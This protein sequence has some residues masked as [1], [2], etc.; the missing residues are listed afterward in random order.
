MKLT[1]VVLV[2]VFLFSAGFS[3]RGN[4]YYFS[5]VTGDDTR[6]STQ[7]QQPATPWK[8]ISKLNAYF[9]SL[10]PG[11]TVFLQCGSVFTGPLHIRQ[12]GS[13]GHPIVITSYGT[14]AAPVIS[15]FSTLTGWVSAGGNIWQSSCAACGVRVNILDVADS[16][17]PM[18]RY[19]NSGGSN[20]GYA[21]VQQHTD[22]T[23]IT[24]ASLGLGQNWTGADLVL[25]KNRYIIERDSILLHSGNTIRYK[26]ASAVAATDKFG[27]FIQNSVKTLDK[28]GEWYYD[29]KTR[30]MNMYWSL[31]PAGIVIKA[32]Q[33][34]TLVDII[35]RQYIQ[36]KG[37]SFEGSNRVGFYL[38]QSGNINFTNCSLR[39]SGIDGIKGIQSNDLTFQGVT[40]EYTNNNAIDL[41]GSRSMIQ[42]CNILRTAIF[43]G[44]G[45]AINSYTGI[46]IYGSNNTI[47]YNRIDTTG[48][49]PISFVGASNAVRNNLIDYFAFVKDDG[50]G[51][52]TWSGD[53][54]V[55]TRR[56]TGWITGNI[57]LNGVT[58]PA[59][60][61]G[62]VAGI[63]H[64]IYLDF[65]TG[66]ATI[67][68][69]TV[70]NCTAGIFA[71]DSHELTVSGNTFFNN[72]GQIVFRHNVPTGIMRNNDYSGNI[73]VSLKDNQYNVV[74]SSIASITGPPALSSFAYMH[75]NKFAQVSGY[76]QFFLLAMQGLNNSGSFGLW[77]STYGFDWNSTLLPANFAPYTV[78]QLI[79]SDLY[80]YDASVTTN[81]FTTALNSSRVIINKPIGVLDSGR[82]YVT[83]FTLHA[84]DAAHTLQVYLQQY[85][86]PYTHY[87]PVIS[88]TTGTPYINQT[89][90]F[91][92]TTGANPNA[93]L[94]FQMNQSDPRIYIDNVDLYLANITP[95]DPLT[96]C[97]FRYNAS[98]SPLVIS[99]NG[100]YQDAAG[101]A[102]Q[103]NITLPPFSSIVLFK[104]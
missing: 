90:F 49:A 28:N 42:D 76:S 97:L 24:D 89:V 50:G 101:T 34:D 27:Y 85:T 16:S 88:V 79:G 67:S 46:K 26:T 60:T 41:D 45:N 61:N 69:N 81:P 92:G 21:V 52:Y 4:K 74:A 87:T 19:P 6:T 36:F 38:L 51:I 72:S 2:F 5:S 91:N 47:Q 98:K 8:T 14:G 48:Y 31:N 58:V 22:S 65:N 73:A 56:V 83:H 96:Y 68:G 44:T 7:A 99:L 94:V 29:P 57:V 12:S 39:F 35:K 64:G 100:I 70:S 13:S 93:S 55:D 20:G 84:P 75:A 54:S 59:G 40:V 103:G 11:D 104:K 17:Q 37:I 1:S 23:T 82:S 15:G 10:L 30:M 80:P 18:G 95:N 32:S 25:R 102:Y 33:V 43:P 63:A 62:A 71:Q 53:I 86:T 78:N 77:K 9:S 66:V 3:A